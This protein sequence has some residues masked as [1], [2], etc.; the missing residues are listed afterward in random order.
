MTK[1]PII[2]AEIGINHNGSFAVAKQ[3]IES[4][5]D[6][7]VDAVKFQFR[8]LNNTYLTKNE[9]GDEVLSAEINE[10]ALTE[11]QI[12]DLAKYA[13]YLG[14]CVGISFFE[15]SDVEIFGDEIK[16]FD[17]F[18]VPSVELRNENLIDKLLL[19][20]KYLLIST[21]ASDEESIEK[22]F[23]RL[24]KKLWMPLHCI[25]NYP[26]AT[27]NSKL[28]Y[29]E[30]LAKKWN[31]PIGYSSHDQNW[32]ICIAAI[33]LGAKV[34]ERHITLD[35]KS[36]GLDHTSSSTPDEFKLIVDFARN[37]NVLFQGFAPRIPNQGELLNLQN[38]GRS[39]YAKRHINAG[40]VVTRDDFTYLSP[41][42]GLSYFDFKIHEGAK[43]VNEI[44]AGEVLSFFH[45]K[46]RA[47]IS[48]QVIDFAN[49][50]NIGLPVRL[51]DYKNISNLFA[52]DNYEF[53][54]SFGEI[55]LLPEYKK[56][57]KLHKFTVHL[58][59]YL[60][61]NELINPFSTKSEIKSRSIK[62]IK[63][64]VDFAK[65]LS[66]ATGNRVGIVGSFSIAENGVENFYQDCKQFIASFSNDSTFLA[67]QWLPPVAWYFGGSVELNLMNNLNDVKHILKNNIN[68]V[69]DTSHLFMGKNSFDFDPCIVIK[70]LKPMTKW[71]HI[72]GASGTDGEGR[73]FKSLSKSEFKIMKDILDNNNVKIVEVWQGHLNKYFGFQQALEN[74]YERFNDE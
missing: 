7:G 11:L 19:L 26:T 38:L 23:S 3:L 29:I 35:K 73:D 2:I 63:S 67:V 18:K 33:I 37:K 30:F 70:D 66:D 55:G 62:I 21:G 14:L 42:T 51:H 4:A 49:F 41:K 20:N 72:S 28:G 31:K 64:S 52:I 5:H 12:A 46:S 17:F 48:L 22:S 16:Y 69:M 57:N 32:S 25:S 71:Y 47:P 74:I 40:E 68:I 50:K 65:R 13:K 61:P 27:Y 24:E 34:I 1:H 6:A 44:Q 54:L 10:N 56:I 39:Y 8:N 36:P 15:A 9:I 45:I 59:D 58:P 53:H 60:S 43:I